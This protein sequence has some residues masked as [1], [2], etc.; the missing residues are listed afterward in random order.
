MEL[1]KRTV[2]KVDSVLNCIANIREHDRRLR[3]VE[4]QVDY[5]SEALTWLVESL[6]QSD[7]VK[8]A[9][10]PPTFTDSA[11]KMDSKP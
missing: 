1:L 5:C 9:K 10:A 3:V 8:N 2:Q 11:H 6:M 7:L 4:K